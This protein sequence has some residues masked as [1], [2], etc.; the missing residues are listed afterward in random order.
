MGS[1][2]VAM[3]NTSLSPFLL[4]GKQKWSLWLMR[5]MDSEPFNPTRKRLI[6][7]PSWTGTTAS[8]ASA[9]GMM[10]TGLMLQET[11]K[12]SWMPV[13]MVVCSEGVR[14]SIPL[15]SGCITHRSFFVP[16]TR[17][18][19]NATKASLPSGSQS[20]PWMK[21]QL[22]G[23]QRAGMPAQIDRVDPE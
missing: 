2:R 19:G 11:G 23:Q 7:P 6:C 4:S 5:L 18:D 9:A 22:A 12:W 1:S 20:A 10:G 16:Y 14:H 3:P 8:L 15:P 13:S 21:P 17:S